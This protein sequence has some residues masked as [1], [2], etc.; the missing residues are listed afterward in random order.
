VTIVNCG[1]L[2]RAVHPVSRPAPNAPSAPPPDNASTI[3]R[4]TG[5][6]VTTELRLD[7]IAGSSAQMRASGMPGMLAV[8]SS[9]WV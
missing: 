4:S 2:P 7:A 9:C 3:G 1:R 8:A 5:T 6:R